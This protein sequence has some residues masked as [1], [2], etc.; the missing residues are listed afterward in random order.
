MNEEPWR[1]AGA[2]YEEFEQTAPT[3][4]KKPAVQP[5]EKGFYQR[6]FYN[7]L[8]VKWAAEQRDVNSLSAKESVVLC[9]LAESAHHKYFSCTLSQ[10]TISDRSGLDLSTVKRALKMLKQKRLVTIKGRCSSPGKRTSNQYILAIV[11]KGHAHWR[12]HLKPEKDPETPDSDVP[13]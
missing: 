9:V 6:R 13:F 3:I 2:V 7:L 12:E 10:K 4:E 11:R 5:F 8:A 1:Q